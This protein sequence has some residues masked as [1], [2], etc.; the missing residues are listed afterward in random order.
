MKKA[1]LMFAAAFG[2]ASVSSAQLGVGGG[3]SYLTQSEHFGIGVKANYQLENNF[4]PSASFTYFLSKNNTTVTLL[5]IDAEYL[6]NIDDALSVYPSVGVRHITA[7][8]SIGSYSASASSFFLPLGGGLEYRMG[9][10]AFQAE[11]RYLVA[12]ESGDKGTFMPTIGAQY[13]FGTSK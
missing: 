10:I 8:A 11:L 2:F 3:L 9:S 6:L 12:L 13:T 4:R 5:G 7:T 1:F